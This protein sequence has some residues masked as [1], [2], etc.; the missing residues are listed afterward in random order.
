MKLP[1]ILGHRGARFTAPE[2][3]LISF[4]NTVRCGA[5]GIELDVHLTKDGKLV[6][7]HDADLRRI[8]GKKT[9][10]KNLTLKEVKNLDISKLIK[11]GALSVKWNIRV[12][13]L[14]CNKYFVSVFDENSGRIYKYF[15]EII[16]NRVKSVKKVM[17]PS[18]C[19]GDLVAEKFIAINAPYSEERFGK[20]EIP[21]FSEVLEKVNSPF[22]N[23]EIKRGERFYPGISDALVKAIEH[24]GFEKFLI[25]S[26]NLSTLLYVKEK[27]P[28]L[29][30]NRL[31]EIPLSPVKAAKSL[32]GVN[33]FSLLIG[34]KGITKL[35]KIGKTV[36][37]WV[38]NNPVSMVKFF[39]FGS[40]GIITDRP[41]FAVKLRAELEGL[42]NAAVR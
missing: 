20:V 18:N 41:C 14:S 32:D 2:N 29:K 10:I 34:R 37:P 28:F 13:A 33:P 11:K 40:D 12:F 17:I 36:F 22:I 5:D 38:V 25:S 6:V 23:V 30:V 7:I 19:E 4:K 31:Y 42:F 24:Y 15:V 9:L 39:I 1:L 21:E 16:G 3:S 8:T 35:H 27:Y 26:F